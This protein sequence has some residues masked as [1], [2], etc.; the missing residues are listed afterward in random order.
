[1]IGIGKETVK[2]LLAHNAKVYI[3]ARNTERVGKA[4]QNLNQETGK[5]ALFLQLDLADLR[6]VKAAAEE[7][8]GK[9]KELHVLFNNT[10]V[11]F[12]NSVFTKILTIYCHSCVMI[13]P[14]DMLTAQGFDLQFWHERP[15][16]FLLYEAPPRRPFS[17]RQIKSGW[18]RTRS[19]HLLIG[20][21]LR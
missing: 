11:A 16:S 19:E 18:S 7:F 4:I 2:A 20:V 14:I 5:E 12:L 3:A 17:W 1:M 13:P 10:L 6:S 9:E 8:N 21:S 15:W